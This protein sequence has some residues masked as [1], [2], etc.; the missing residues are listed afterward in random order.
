[1]LSSLADIKATVLARR[2]AKAR[3][4]SGPLAG[5]LL[6]LKNGRAPRPRVEGD[7]RTQTRA[8]AGMLVTPN[9]GLVDEQS[10]RLDR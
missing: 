1:M 5:R 10:E 9:V 6:E 4:M 3:G 7:P 8:A 2:S